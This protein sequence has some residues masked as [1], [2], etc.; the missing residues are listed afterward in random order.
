VEKQRKKMSLNTFQIG[1]IAHPLEIQWPPSHYDAGKKSRAIK[2]L[3]DD[4]KLVEEIK[5]IDATLISEDDNGHHVLRLKLWQTAMV[6]L[7]GS[8]QLLTV[9]DLRYGDKITVMAKPYKWTFEGR[10]G[11]SLTANHVLVVERGSADRKSVA[12]T[13]L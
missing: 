3:V 10:R 8:D 6:Q 2:C 5:A 1:S 7:H 9:D 4:E 13:W 11:T 12:P